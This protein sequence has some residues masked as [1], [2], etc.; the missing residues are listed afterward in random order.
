MMSLTESH[1]DEWKNKMKHAQIRDL[2]RK[3]DQPPPPEL[4]KTESS[5]RSISDFFLN[6]SYAWGYDKLGK[7]NLFDLFG[8][9]STEFLYTREGHKVKFDV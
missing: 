5:K 9:A 7:T 6:K 4:P 1:L 3:K 8:A 2:K